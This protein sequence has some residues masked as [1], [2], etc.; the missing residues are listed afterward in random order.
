MS[1]ITEDS[2]LNGVEV[3]YNQS[4]GL[5]RA[6]DELQKQYRDG[7]L[8]IVNLQSYSTNGHTDCP[9]WYEIQSYT[10]KRWTPVVD[11]CKFYTSHYIGRFYFNGYSIIINPRY[12]NIFSYLISYATNLYLPL[13]S[14][15]LEYNTTSNSYWLIALIWKALL[16]KALT[17]GQIP[18][19]YKTVQKNQKHFK[20]HL[21]ISKH[22]HSNICNASRFFCSYKKL[23]MDNAINQ[24][25]RAVYKVLKGKGVGTI[26]GEFEAYDKYLESMG[27]GSIDIVNQIESIKY[28]RLN[29]AYRPVMRLSKTIL[30]NQKAQSVDGG[31]NSDISYFID[32]AELWEI[33][34]L[35]LLQNNLPSEYKVFSPNSLRGESLLDNDMREIRP[36][37]L[38]SKNGVVEMVIDAKYKHYN[39]FGATSTFGIQREDLYQMTTY[40]Y[41]YGEE[42]R[43][44]VGIFTAPI[45]CCDNDIHTY[46]NNRNHK[47]GLVNLDITKDSIE[48][49][50][51]AEKKYIETII[52]LLGSN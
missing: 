22:I 25:I 3:Y 14:S 41:H 12:G 9:I 50:H 48:S 15:N 52:N 43:N 11:Q 4:A 5:M 40:L 1:L 10:T 46:R 8:D 34:L 19:E 35:R 51:L 39:N 2:N 18:R 30:S 24:T 17:F 49:I 33:Y 37:I 16:N 6:V 45:E 32:I 38:I 36:D 27:V 44:I 28:T 42:N 47:I 31:Q 13:G 26:I 20:G 7:T 29:D 21:N 23:S